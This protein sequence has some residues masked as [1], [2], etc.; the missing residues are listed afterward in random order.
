MWWKINYFQKTKLGTYNNSHGSDVNKLSEK[1][2]KAIKTTARAFLIINYLKVNAPFFLGIAV[3][4]RPEPSLA[5]KIY[6]FGFPDGP[7]K[8]EFSNSQHEQGY[9][10]IFL[11]SMAKMQHVQHAWALKLTKIKWKTKRF[12]FYV[13]ITKWIGI[14]K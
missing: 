4:S 8:W 7:L 6:L 14:K 11:P 1:L 3:L 2:G 12:S 9:V 5:T 10:K 13:N